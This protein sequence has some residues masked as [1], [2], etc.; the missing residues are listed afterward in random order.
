MDQFIGIDVHTTSCSIA[1]VNEQGR[2][3][4]KSVIST[5]PTELVQAIQAIPRPRHI[6]IEEGNLS[7]SVHEVLEPH[8]D[9]FTVTMVE[10][11]KQ[12]R[13]KDDDRD[14]L[15]LANRLRTGTVKPV[16]WSPESLADFV[17]KLWRVGNVTRDAA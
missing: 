7:G 6:C 15:D 14:A 17:R 11:R 9:S 13:S 10:D 1:R 4:G 8:S 3:L 12:S 2:I 16:L 5:S